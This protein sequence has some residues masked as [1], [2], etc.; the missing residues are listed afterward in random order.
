MAATALPLRFMNVVGMSRRV[1][2]DRLICP[3]R[4]KTGLGAQRSAVLPGQF[5]R[6]VGTGVV[7]GTPVF[8]TGVT[9]AN[10]QLDCSQRAPPAARGLVLAVAFAGGLCR[11]RRQL[12][13]HYHPAALGVMIEAIAR[14]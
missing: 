14:S 9:E 10:D 1:V 11:R 2:A 8:A 5:F 12:R 4:P 6:E 13:H 7:P 3:A